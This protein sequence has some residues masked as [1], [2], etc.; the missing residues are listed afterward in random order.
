MCKIF[1]KHKFSIAQSTTQLTLW[2]FQISPIFGGIIFHHFF[3][4]Y[5]RYFLHFWRVIC[6]WFYNLKTKQMLKKKFKKNNC[7]KNA[8]CFCRVV[9]TIL[10]YHSQ[11]ENDQFSL[12]AILATGSKNRFSKTDNRFDYRYYYL[13]CPL[14]Y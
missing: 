14:F 5:F 9:E 2:T 6:L 11:L 10:V 4:Q 8:L 12:Y 3:Q 7:W 1:S 13:F